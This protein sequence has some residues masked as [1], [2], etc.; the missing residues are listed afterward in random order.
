MALR[1][2]EIDA[3]MSRVHRRNYPTLLK[4]TTL[5]LLEPDGRTKSVAVSTPSGLGVITGG[6]GAGKTTLLRA[7]QALSEYRTQA[8]PSRLLRADIVGSHDGEPW[9]IEAIRYGESA[10]PEVRL[11]RGTKPP[12]V[13]IDPALESQQIR[14]VFESDS[15]ASDLL[16][17]ADPN[18]FSDDWLGHASRI[19]R[20]RYT[21]VE[22]TEIEGPGDEEVIPWFRTSCAGAEYTSL[23]MGRGELSALYLLW[24]LSQVPKNT[25]VVIDEPEAGLA[26]YS[27]DKLKETFAHLSFSL[28]VHLIISTHSPSLYL[29]LAGEPVS[30]VESVPSPSTFGPMSSVE[31]ARHLG[32]PA[33]IKVALFAEDEVAAELTSS[34]LR[35]FDPS[36]AAATEVFASK[37]GES[38]LSRFVDDFA[39]YARSNKRLKLLVIYDGDQRSHDS[40][41]ESKKEGRI[42][43]PGDFAPEEVVR[44]IVERVVHAESDDFLRS[45]GVGDPLAFKLVLSRNSGE[46]HHDWFVEISR[47]FGGYAATCDVLVRICRHDG[48]FTRD[49]ADLVSR[50]RELA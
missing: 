45:S 12:L 46:D 8:W 49:A 29:G 7:L 28:G 5:H 19:L 44:N 31:A 37:N 10:H 4:E 1:R 39:S 27:Q 17:G 26:A 36:V 25:I 41:T 3:A 23:E 34:I 47:E 33:G 16:E 9:E 21:S 13:F 40:R 48:S 11:K 20:R 2:A 38:S 18:A 24:R 50:V 22:V 43:L 6:N 32:A 14:T 35:S 30:V 42:Y 15:N